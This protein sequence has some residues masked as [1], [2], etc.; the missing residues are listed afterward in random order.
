M[1]HRLSNLR[2]SGKMVNSSGAASTPKKPAATPK[3]P[4]TPA[5]GKGSIKAS[6]KISSKKVAMKDI[7]F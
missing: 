1:G 3:A 7:S 6:S 2:N 4:H 5:S